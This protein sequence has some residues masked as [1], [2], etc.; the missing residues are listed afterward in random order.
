[1]ARL[2]L[3]DPIAAE[4]MQRHLNGSEPSGVLGQL[5]R[6]VSEVIDALAVEV[7]F[8]RSLADGM[9]RLLA[10]GTPAGLNRYRGLV[11]TAAVRG[12][13]LAGLFARHLVPVLLCSDASLADRFEATT[14]VMLQKGTYTLKAP[15]ETLTEMIEAQDLGCAHAFLDLLAIAYALKTSYNRTVYLTHTLPRAVKQFA[16]SRRLWQIRGLARVLGQDE[17]LAD[18]YLQGLKAGLHLLSPGALNAFLD[19]A[20]RRHRQDPDLGARFLALES[21]Q[22]AEWCR[23]LQV[24]VPLSAVRSVLE[25]YL[26]ARTG[27][28]VAVRPLSSLPERPV[29][30]AAGAALVRCDGRAIYLPDEMDLMPQRADNITLYKLLVG[31]EAGPIEFGTYDLDVEKAFDD[32]FPA[33]GSELTDAQAAGSDL[34]RF[35]SRFDDPTMALDLFTLF[36]HGRIAQR[37]KRNYPG[38]FRRLALAL[39]DP[40]LPAQTGHRI[41]GTLLPLYR[42]LVMGQKLVADS[43]L[44]AIF[45]AMSDRLKALVS[46]GTDTAESSARLAASFYGQL[47]GHPAISG[48]SA[49]RPFCLPFGRRLEPALFFPFHHTAQR[50][51]AKIQQRLAQHGL[52]AYRSDMR[53]L[54]VQQNG[55]LSVADLHSLMLQPVTEPV[56]LT[57]ARLDLASLTCSP[58]VERP[59]SQCDHAHAFRYREWDWCMQ[60]YLPDRVRVRERELSGPSTRFYQETL[61]QFH[62]LVRRI[63][64]AF[65]LLRPEGLTVLRQWPEGD[66]FDYRALLDYAVDKK[67]GLMP[68]D[69]LFIKR[70]KKVRDVA[71]LLLVDVSRST[72]NAVDDRGT[73]VLDVEKQAIVLLCE[74]LTVVGD[75]FAV[76]GFSGTGPLGVDYFRIKDLDAPFDEIV[77]G[78]IGAMAPQR[79]TRMGAAI[80]HATALLAPVPSRDRL[81]IIL[82]DGFPNDLAYKGPYAVED[83]RRAVME[84]RTAAI[85][86]KAITVNVSDNRQLDRLYG[87]N[88]H[89]R[90]GNV[91]DLPDKLVRVYSRLT[92]P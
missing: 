63:R 88:H 55:Q 18:A 50:L 57:L 33:T 56:A 41:G 58:G 37:V 66:D 75:R 21:G 45:S 1:M 62:G 47:A 85:H 43:A 77:K 16:P 89:T 14:R 32:T 23:E 34:D 80:R 17:R 44:S 9:G 73:C 74:A 28:A 10:G 71:A 36:E 38:L 68:S 52:R 26:H 48:Q 46:P 30:A 90:I 70:L 24:A 13:T 79:S 53:R 27:M 82:G 29:Q 87:S 15:L 3:A 49:F 40:R 2:A 19:Q 35:I 5:E 6:V 84:A 61:D 64:Y 83:T 60:D 20:V 59:T 91:H 67:A 51:A 72:A 69:R 25:R 12:P 7:S 8:G 4:R 42:H 65:E 39:S 81:I 78:R 11:R 31:L 22:A 86:V 92:R 54:L 76:A